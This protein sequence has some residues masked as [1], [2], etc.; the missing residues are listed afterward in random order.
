[1]DQLASICGVAGSALLID[2]RTFEIE[3]V[4]IPEDLAVLVVH[5]GVPRQLAKS[6]YAALTEYPLDVLSLALQRGLRTRYPCDAG[7]EASPMN[8]SP[9]G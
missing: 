7:R 1:M 6:E 3:A 8:S 5:S 9:A 2:C 4:P